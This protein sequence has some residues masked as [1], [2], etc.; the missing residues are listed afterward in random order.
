ME[1]G[2]SS[3]TY[4]DQMPPT[5]INACDFF[6]EGF[7]VCLDNISFN[8][9]DEL[10]RSVLESMAIACIF[11]V[12][13]AFF[14]LQKSPRSSVACALLGATAFG[15]TSLIVHKKPISVAY[16][17]SH[18]V[19]G[20]LRTS[21]V[22]DPLEWFPGARDFEGHYGDLRREVLYLVDATGDR[23]PLTGLTFGSNNAGI[24]NDV[25]MGTDGKLKG[26]R[27]LVVSIGDSIASGIASHAP[28]LVRLLRDHRADVVSCVISILPPRTHIPRH[29][30]YYKGVLRYML[31]IE[32]P[33]QLP[34]K[35]DVYL[36]VN[37]QT[38]HW[39]E[40]R[41]VMFDDTF[42]HKVYN[43][44]DQRRIVLY[45][46]IRRKLSSPVANFFNRVAIRA[47]QTSSVVRDEVRRT[48]KIL[49]AKG[50]V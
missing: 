46:D 10:G 25:S 50:S 18:L 49:P 8:R 9:N 14:V 43:N 13:S 21:P 23:L 33:K 27:I 22:L 4:I 6:E 48:E 28:T 17:A 37:D 16:A 31:A 38:V 29:V 15:A 40:G 32:V 11:L 3:P 47:M 7:A 2:K 24:G 26:W 30:G 36:C 5:E 34:S 39:E 45:M 12:L 44:T 20:S 42:P 35:Q 1:R 19:G 41:S